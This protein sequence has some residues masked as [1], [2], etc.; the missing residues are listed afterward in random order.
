MNKSTIADYARIKEKYPERY[1]V[2]VNKSE[3]C[4]SIGDIDK[5]KFLVPGDLTVGQFVYII[6]KRIKLSQETALFIFCNDKLPPTAKL[7][8]QI[9]NNDTYTYMYYSSENTFG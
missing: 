2:I 9:C 4:N 3:K 7:M 8:S 1:P 5:T 6:R